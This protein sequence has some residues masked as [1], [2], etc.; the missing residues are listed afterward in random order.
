M[1]DK[2]VYF[3]GDGKADGHEGMKDLLGQK[4]AALAGMTLLGIP[5]PPGF[6]IGTGVCSLYEKNRGK[7]P[8]EVDREI[9]ANLARLER[10]SGKRFGNPK[11]PLLVSVRSG[12]RIPVP[13]LAE[14]ILNLGLN[15]RTVEGLAKRTDDRRFAYDTYR[16]FLTA[17][18]GAVLGIDRD[19]F[20]E[21]LD[22]KRRERNV[23]SDLDL[24][25]EDLKD[26]CGKCRTLVKGR[27]K[28]E[29][30]QDPR[31]QLDLARDA[32]FRSWNGDVARQYRRTNGIPD[33]IGT[34]VSVQE[35]V[36]G[37]LGRDCAA[38]VGFTRK[39]STGI[40]EFQGEYVVDAQGDDLVAG[41]RTPRP[42]QDLKKEMPGV[43]RRLAGI[44]NRLEKRFGDMQ[45]FAFAVERGRLYML[46]SRSGKRTAAAAVKIAVDLVKEKRIP[47]EEALMRIEPQAIEQLL[48][49]VLDPGARKEVLARGVP[50]S[51]GAAS[52]IVVFQP[53][54]AVELAS[55]GRP[56]ILVRRET[57]P[58]DIRGMEA[59]RGILTAKGGMTS[60]AAVVARQLGK[61]CVT[62][63]EALDVD[64]ATNRLAVGGRVIREG[65]SITLD[66]GTGEV[67]LGEVPLLAPRMTGS[68]G[69]LLSW[70]DSLRKLEVR[71]NADTLRDARTAR[72]YGARGIGLCRTEHMFF[73]EDRLPI[74]REMV[75]ARSRPEREEAL[76]KLLPMQREDFREIYREMKGHPVIIRLLDPPLHEFLP[77]R[78]ELLVDVTKLRLIHADRSIIEEK[79]RILDRVEELH[80]RNPMLG[81]RGC[82]LGIVNPEITRMQARA[83]FEAACEVGRQ[84]VRVRPEIMVPLV[85]MA[86]E[87]K[88]QKELIDEV[89]AETM[90]RYRRKFP[91]SVGTMIELPRAALTADEIAREAEF[92]S[93]GT[94]DLTQTTFGFSRDDAGRFLQQYLSRSERCPRCGGALGR[95]L[96]CGDCGARQANRPESILDRD[97]FKTLDQAGVGLLIRMG[98]EKGRKVRPKLVVGVCGEHGGDPESVAMFHRMGLDYVS[99]S[100]YRVPVARLAAARAV[101]EE[102]REARSELRRKKKT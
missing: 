8:A 75:L 101:L 27:T 47:K 37:N 20:E 13:G 66:G 63:C 34:A 49:P 90:K 16:R 73:A 41:F 43:F 97:V 10:T 21:L 45:E 85:S 78:E 70:A 26:L 11:N 84:G 94:N 53:A 39:P 44:A 31:V 22:R 50:A 59:A 72:E 93:F 79:K 5:V 98:V 102:K 83:I 96:S 91:Y 18:S 7:L 81:L 42:L 71:A 19:R 29:F 57:G 15:D 95:D 36:F 33:D 74:M 32:A 60:H 3:F 35:M 9:T 61:T 30:P 2:R 68:F 24:T 87:M 99:C 17:F 28:R 4:G 6:T 100:P 14:T 46:G 56:V 86:R 64:E 38:G 80:E 23:A 88:A 92:F 40:R 48:H 54:R 67:V 25:A 58:D 51:P 76:G 82:R 62:G 55:A 52:G 69:T 12:P 77:R 1:A 89:A 65:E